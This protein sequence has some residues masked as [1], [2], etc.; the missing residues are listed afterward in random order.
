VIDDSKDEAAPPPEASDWYLNVYQPD[1]EGTPAI[2]AD[3]ADSGASPEPEL[4]AGS[5]S[6]PAEKKRSMPFWME[7]PILIGVALIVAVII[8]TFL[9]QAFFIPSGS[10]KE[11]LQIDDRV[12]VSKV[13]YTFGDL[14]YG[15]VIVFDDP[16][17]GFESATDGVGERAI[18][19]LLE[20]IGLATPESEFIKRVV[21]LPGDTVELVMNQLLVNGVR[22]DE[23]YLAA[24]AVP[25]STC[26]SGGHD[27]G[28]QVIP[29]GHVM[30]M[31]DNR[32]HSS[33]G[34]RF[35]PV[36]EDAIVGKA[37]IIIWPPSRW[38]G[39]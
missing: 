25:P 22:I 39:L 37:F 28:P 7:L 29:V 38:S 6:E 5:A 1:G 19:N 31:G 21:A 33:D 18:R 12:L 23:P 2:E 9:F 14:A 35:G 11:T 30:V 20:S 4:E 32:C 8:K 13:S 36:P 27:Y 34:R 26:A 10:M 24:D 16:R 17:G 3:D 15:D